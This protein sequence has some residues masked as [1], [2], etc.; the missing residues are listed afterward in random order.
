MDPDR[1]TYDFVALPNRLGQGSVKWRASED[2]PDLLQLWVADMDFEPFPALRQAI[3][4]HGQ[5]AIFG[6]S[7]PKQELFDAIMSWEKTQHRYQISQDSLVLVSG[8]VPAI[9]I[10]I[11]A[12]TKQGDAVLINS[13]VYPP[14]ANM[15]RLNN[16]RLRRQ[17]LELVNG[18]FQMDMEAF[19]QEFISED[20]KLYLLCN[21]HNPGGRAWSKE[22]LKQIGDICLKHNV[23][24][25]SDEIHQDLTLF[26]HQHHSFN[27]VDKTFADISLVLSSATKTFNLAGTKNSFAII[28]N[29]KLRQAFI[30]QQE[31][32]HQ[33]EIPTIGYLTTQV[34]YESGSQWL[35]A[36]KKVLEENILFL[37]EYLEQHTQIKVMKPQA[38]YLVWLDFS[39]YGLSQAELMNRL[40]STAKVVL[41]NGQAFGPQGKGFARINVAT[42]KATLIE[43]CQRIAQAFPK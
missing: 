9:A 42:P 19:E 23:L 43:A 33:Q 1:T 28:E 16:R 20:I 11:Q 17:P 18:Q 38:T 5:G 30:K 15:V 3:I 27:T 24:V 8:V 22:E 36:L 40:T 6:Y 12:L 4:S 13:P 35:D 10:A 41:N 7:Y 39:A 29:P 26:G 14:F 25:I 21:P 32:N 37:C 2:N 31:R 34:A